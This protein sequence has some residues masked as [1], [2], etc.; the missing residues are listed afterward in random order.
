MAVCVSCTRDVLL[1]G[2]KSLFT[3]PRRCASDEAMLCMRRCV[4]MKQLKQ[5]HSRMIRSGLDSDQLLVRKMIELCSTYGELDYAAAVFDQV[6]EPDTFT[7]NTMIRVY[8]IGGRCRSAL[9]LYNL[10][11]CQGVQPDKFTFP[12]AVKACV[13]CLLLD[14]AKEIHGTAMK[15]GLWKDMFLWNTVMDCYLKCG[16]LSSGRKVFDKMPVRNVVSW[17]IMVAGLVDSGDLDD[18]RRVFEQ[19]PERNVVTWSVMID[20][21]VQSQLPEDAFELLRRMQLENVRP[22][23][24]TL[25]SLL[26]ASSDLE[27][28]KLGGWIHDFALKNGLEIGVFLGTALIDMYSK[29]GSLAGA[30]RVFEMMRSRSVA[31]WNTMITSLGVHGFADEALDLFSVMEKAG[32]RPDAITFVAVLSACVNIH[33][34]NEGY[35]FFKRMIERYGITPVREHYDCMIELRRWAKI[36]HGC[37]LGEDVPLGDGTSSLSSSCPNGV[38]IDG[39]PGLKSLN[40]ALYPSTDQTKS[41][42]WDAG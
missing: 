20:G 3:L 32:P 14:K 36:L 12:F 8:N 39:E 9:M 41:F 42:M 21:Y 13:D 5:I 17:T 7:W 35:T 30:K 18:A 34:F 31:T 26:R 37:E 24:F 1:L 16:D 23:E 25:V 28:L 19:M 22:N 10:I 38:S 6:S 40:V 33:N 29:C 2:G 27:S 15:L 4:S 11:I